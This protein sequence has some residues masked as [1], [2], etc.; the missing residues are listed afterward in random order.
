[1]KRRD[2]WLPRLHGYLR[3]TARA[4]FAWGR[5]DCALHAAGA[6]EAVTGHDP[7]ADFRGRYTTP[8]GAVRVLRKAGHESLEAMVD[9]LA[10]RQ[11][12]LQA[13]AGDLA[14]VKTEDG[15]ALGVVQ[16]AMVAVVTERGRGLVPLTS[17]AWS[18][19]IG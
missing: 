5:Y 17:C 16:G 11:V 18:W 15:V 12:V 9:G 7:A 10:P 2:D 3:D 6:V 14:A 19:R 1:M 8:R 4:P 13:R